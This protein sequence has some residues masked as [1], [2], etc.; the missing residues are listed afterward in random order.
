M[1]LDIGSREASWNGTEVN[2]GFAPEFIDDQVFVHGLDLQKKSGAA[3]V[4]AAADLWQSRHR[5]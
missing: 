2:L 4:R 5:D 3:V 1:V